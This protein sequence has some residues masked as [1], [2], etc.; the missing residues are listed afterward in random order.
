MVV[1]GSAADFLHQSGEIHGG[2]VQLVGIE[3]DL[4]LLAEITV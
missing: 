3:A 2:D 4:S 1:D